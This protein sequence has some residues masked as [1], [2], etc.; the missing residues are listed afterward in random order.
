M[1]A[2]ALYFTRDEL[3]QEFNDEVKKA[4]ARL[5]E[6]HPHIFLNEKQQPLHWVLDY[7]P[8]IERL[9]FASIGDAAKKLRR[10]GRRWAYAGG[11]N[12]RRG[13]LIGEELKIK[14]SKTETFAPAEGYPTPGAFT[15]ENENS[16]LFTRSPLK[17]R[18][19]GGRVGFVED[20]KG[21]PSRAYLKLW[22]AFTLTGFYPDAA[23]TVL[24]LGA[25]PGGW[26][27]VAASLGSKVTM[28]D[29]ARP[30][31]I[32]FKKFPKIRFI[33]G[34][35]LN[36][37]AAEL[38]QA[39]VILSDMACE[40]AKLIGSVR[41]WLKLP[42][43]TAMICTLKFHG[44]SDKRLIHDFADIPGGKIYH[45]WHNGHELTWVWLK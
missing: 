15:L 43:L 45:L 10:I 19:A 23:T 9:E 39:T 18:F 28:I 27:Y 12:F 26:S 13:Q 20:K 35:G 8:D 24:D 32:L 36:P 4:G 7:W 30:D 41:A 17:G 16:L 34:D 6:I 33:T 37:A 21:P 1:S 38:A 42:Q 22:E 5:K 25:T 44:L 40:P 14:K 31:E 11:A 3:A 29:R 2:G